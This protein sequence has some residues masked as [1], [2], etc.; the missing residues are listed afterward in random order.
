[1]MNIFSIFPVFIVLFLFSGADQAQAHGVAAA[2]SRISGIEITA[3]YD[4]GQPFAGADLIV[5]APDNPA[6]AWTNGN[7][8]E[9]GKF[10]FVP[11]HSIPGTWSVQIRKTGHGT[12][13]HIPV[14]DMEVITHDAPS[15]SLTIAQKVV[16]AISIVW[17]CIGTA[18]FFS[19][20]NKKGLI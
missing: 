18:L 17:G 7:L 4:N 5:Y 19:T 11:D 10:S 6:E 20:R 13:I 9:R 12:M 14:S 8:D 2:Y 1:M 16:I 15:G 3:A